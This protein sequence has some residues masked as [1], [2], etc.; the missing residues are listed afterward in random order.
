MP[1]LPIRLLLGAGIIIVGEVVLLLVE[2][3][4]IQYLDFFPSLLVD[5]QMLLVQILPVVPFLVV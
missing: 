2:D 1:T 5:K 4:Q 3:V